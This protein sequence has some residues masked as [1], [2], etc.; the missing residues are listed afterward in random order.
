[1][2]LEAETPRGNGMSM[3]P[4]SVSNSPA[5]VTIVGSSLD[6]D[7]DLPGETSPANH[8]KNTS[9]S[10][11]EHPRRFPRGCSRMDPAE[12]REAASSSS[13]FHLERP[14][15]QDESRARDFSEEEREYVH[16][17][18]QEGGV[19]PFSLP[20]KSEDSPSQSSYYCSTAFQREAHDF[21]KPHSADLPH[22]TMTIES[23]SVPTGE[24]LPSDHLTICHQENPLTRR[25]YYDTR[26]LDGRGRK[27]EPWK[28]VISVEPRT[29]PAAEGGAGGESMQR[30]EEALP[31]SS[32]AEVHNAQE[33]DGGDSGD[34]LSLASRFPYSSTQN[35]NAFQNEHQTSQQTFVDQRQTM[36]AD[37]SSNALSCWERVGTEVVSHAVSPQVMAVGGMGM[38]VGDVMD[39][40][41]GGHSLV[42]ESANRSSNSFPVGEGG[43]PLYHAEMLTVD[44]RGGGPDQAAWRGAAA[45]ESAYGGYM[46]SSPT[47]SDWDCWWTKPPVHPYG[48]RECLTPFSPFPRLAGNRLVFPHFLPPKV[49]WNRTDAASIPEQLVSAVRQFFPPPQ[50]PSSSSTW[51]LHSESANFQVNVSNDRHQSAT[52]HR[53][54]AFSSSGVPLSCASQEGALQ[55][56]VRG[57]TGTF[58]G[59]EGFRP[60][61]VSQMTLYEADEEEES[62]EEGEST[63]QTDTVKDSPTFSF[64]PFSKRKATA[65]EP[66]DTQFSE[67]AF[68]QT[69]ALRMTQ[70]DHRREKPGEHQNE[71]SEGCEPSH[72]QPPKTAPAPTVQP[73]VWMASSPEEAS[74][75][76]G[77]TQMGDEWDGQEGSVSSARRSHAGGGR[78]ADPDRIRRCLEDVVAREIRVVA[79]RLCLQGGE[80][81]PSEQSQKQKK[82]SN[83]FEEMNKHQGGR[84][85]VGGEETGDGIREGSSPVCSLRRQSDPCGTAIRRV[86]GSKGGRKEEEE[87]KNRH[88]AAGRDSCSY[89][90]LS[91]SALASRE[92]SNKP[93]ESPT[94]ERGSRAR[95]SSLNSSS[96]G[97]SMR[98]HHHRAVGQQ[99]PREGGPASPLPD[100]KSRTAAKNGGSLQKHE[101]ETRQRGALTTPQPLEGESSIPFPALSL[102]LPDNHRSTVTGV[103]RLSR[104]VDS[105]RPAAH[106]HTG[107]EET[108]KKTPRDG[109]KSEDFQAFTPPSR[110]QPRSSTA[111]QR[112]SSKSSGSF[113]KREQ[114][115]E[116][117]RERESQKQKQERER[118][119]DRSRDHLSSST[120]AT[121][122]VPTAAPSLSASGSVPA[123]KRG[124]RRRRRSRM[125]AVSGNSHPEG[126]GDSI[127]EEDEEGGNGGKA[128]EEFV[129]HRRHSNAGSDDSESGM[130]PGD[131]ASPPSSVSTGDGNNV[132]LTHTT[133]PSGLGALTDSSS[134]VD[135]SR[136]M[137][138]QEGGLSSKRQT[139]KERQKKMHPEGFHREAEGKQ[140]VD[141]DGTHHPDAISHLCQVTA[142][143]RE[144][145]RRS[146]HREEERDAVVVELRS[147][148]AGLSDRLARTAAKVSEHA[149]L[150]AKAALRAESLEKELKSLKGLFARREADLVGQK[151]ASDAATETANLKLKRTKIERDAL[152]SKLKR[153][154]DEAAA[155]MAELR[156]M[157]EVRKRLE[158][159]AARL[160]VLE[161]EIA[162]ARCV[163]SPSDEESGWVGGGNGESGE[164]GAVSPSARS[165]GTCTVAP[166]DRERAASRE[167]SGPAPHPMHTPVQPH[168]VVQTR[169][170]SNGPLGGVGSSLKGGGSFGFV[171]GGVHSH[172]HRDRGEESTGGGE[173]RRSKDLVKSILAA[174]PSSRPLG[175]KAPG[176]FAIRSGAGAPSKSSAVGSGR[177]PV[178]GPGGTR[179]S[180][181]TQQG[182]GGGGDGG[183][184]VRRR[185]TGGRMGTGLEGGMSRSSVRIQQQQKQKAAGG[186]RSCGSDEESHSVQRKRDGLL[187]EMKGPG[188]S[189][190]VPVAVSVS[191]PTSGTGMAA[192]PAAAVGDSGEFLRGELGGAVVVPVPV[193]AGHSHAA[194]GEGGPSVGRP[195]AC[196]GSVSS[197]F[198]D[199]PPVFLQGGHNGGGGSSPLPTGSSTRTPVPVAAAALEVE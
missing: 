28:D 178:Q 109:R 60:T 126:E 89:S 42:A 153:A 43:T 26:P 160:E 69:T 61:P 47:Y 23:F 189:P 90:F 177:G 54:T 192:V 22:A 6:A 106:P 35:F 193:R 80:G 191:R 122:A 111:P 179:A 67:E 21:V 15:T 66:T 116:T 56:S 97:T 141:L 24:I 198:C 132:D 143:L 83:C 195:A 71:E 101:N 45:A 79:D 98:A 149:T 18:E 70:S 133:R 40:G 50:D 174:A 115:E 155:R 156:S 170:S 121:R 62:E 134:S 118:E 51:G 64:P 81:E 175:G 85:C 180:E 184:V 44:G 96:L 168:V 125:K 162:N 19:I 194:R 129:R 186:S 4:Q 73:D 55:R 164:A 39:R 14:L 197:G 34:S 169:R 52:W 27:R 119:K 185:V 167:R 114:M 142:Q 32:S 128:A 113:E 91:V 163:S 108:P 1:M 37:A 8:M 161:A 99:R 88:K 148:V 94:Q 145:L 5:S 199:A 187:E 12:E 137:M 75:L 158:K 139:D 30:G 183:A 78:T 49:P 127:G 92:R 74:R 93:I 140:S 16:C 76:L 157:A 46:S 110:T 17:V 77:E 3:Y 10:S 172:S 11:Q 65:H 182:G 159:K 136:H 13:A 105:R 173:T 150:H 59:D 112:A 53:A 196:G 102:S 2:D 38:G 131:H 25:N 120:N 123:Q 33:G 130:M 144:E 103:D 72:V 165:R 87:E 84:G 29:D 181:R 147:A 154:E 176:S 190:P 146:K 100:R 20:P 117:E 9:R 95:R 124:D 41:R 48:V 82:R 58:L 135:R 31:S 7:F 57:G 104:G 36:Y 107:W 68:D 188:M 166:R 138:H 152:V 151:E 86:H 63:A 171:S